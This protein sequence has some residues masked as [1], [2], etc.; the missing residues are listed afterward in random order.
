MNTGSSA[1][2]CSNSDACFPRRARVVSRRE[3]DL[4]FKSGRRAQTAILSLHFLADDSPPRL[5]LAVSRKVDSRAVVRNRIKRRLREYFRR[6][7]PILANGA[8]VVVARVQAAKSASPEL[9]VAFRTALHRAGA[10]P[11]SPTDGTM[12]SVSRSS[13]SA[14]VASAA[15]SPPAP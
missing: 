1:G 13:A 12:P 4:V 2:S 8:Y 5:G 10:L 7:R 11:A 9:M 6:Q 15:T 3:F 14:T